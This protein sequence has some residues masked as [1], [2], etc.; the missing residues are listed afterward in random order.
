MVV[1][2]KTSWQSYIRRSKGRRLRTGISPMPR[3]LLTSRRWSQQEYGESMIMM[4]CG[5]SLCALAH[6]P[7]LFFPAVLK[8]FYTAFYFVQVECK[9]GITR[10][11]SPF[12]LLE[13]ALPSYCPF[14][15]TWPNTPRGCWPCCCNPFSW[16]G[17]TEVIHE[18][19]QWRPL[20]WECSLQIANTPNCWLDSAQEEK[21]DVFNVRND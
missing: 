12:W 18:D 21:I 17:P 20:I 4:G 9:L 3:I 14:L 13:W 10:V 2:E 1:C 7:C 19:I 15:W 16:H 5:D 11:Q 8:I 6:F